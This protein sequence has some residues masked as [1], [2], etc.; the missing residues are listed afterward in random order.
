MGDRVHVRVDD[1]GR[2]MPELRALLAAKG[3]ADAEVTRV[4]PGIEDVFVALLGTK[5]P[6]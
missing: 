3:I 4:E 6:A 2:R 5:E 1:A